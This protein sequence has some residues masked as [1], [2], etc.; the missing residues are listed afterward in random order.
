MFL[1]VLPPSQHTHVC[2]RV[3]RTNNINS[4]HSPARLA[5]K[6]ADAVKSLYLNT[7]GSFKFRKTTPI[8]EVKNDGDVEKTEADKKGNEEEWKG[9][10]ADI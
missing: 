8:V 4:L 6:I 2:C 10:E 5:L 9:V 7:S 3:S 1:N